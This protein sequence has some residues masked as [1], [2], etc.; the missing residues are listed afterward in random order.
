MFQWVARLFGRTEKSPIRLASR[1]KRLIPEAARKVLEGA[2]TMIVHSLDPSSPAG[3]IP[4]NFHDWRVLGSVSVE[5]A[6]TRARIAAEMIA[7]NQASDGGP[8]CFN[9][10]HGIRVAS[11][12]QEVD[13]LACFWCSWLEVIGPD[14]VW[15]GMVPVGSGPK[16]ML[17]RL[18][19]KAGV[20]LGKDPHRWI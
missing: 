18:L 8:K 15:G 20:P 3:D 17:D 13:L 11:Q 12:G 9:A 1:P 6:A 7:A 16:R 19:R 14:G 2:E 10:T 4:G 5:C